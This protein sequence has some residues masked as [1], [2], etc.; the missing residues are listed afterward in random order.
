MFRHLVSL[1]AGLLIAGS[2]AAAPEAPP[3]P[4]PG[5]AELLSFVGSLLVVVGSILAFG[6]LYGRF[7]PGMSQGGGEI[8]IVATRPLG[9]KERLLVVELGEQQILVG[10]SPGHM[11]TL[12]TLDAPL[13]ET[14]QA[15]PAVS[16][17]AARFREILKE[18]GR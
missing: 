1:L 13:P 14:G 5:G 4:G 8:R 15:A 16:G 6:W 11:Q 17:F 3:A 12:H 7:R 10:V 2:A 18:S 9:P